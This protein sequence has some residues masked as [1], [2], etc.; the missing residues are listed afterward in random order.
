MNKIQAYKK[1]SS[2]SVKSDAIFFQRKSIK[3]IN[4]V[5]QKQTKKSQ[6]R[7]KQ[8]RTHN[9]SGLRENCYISIFDNIDKMEEL[10]GKH[11]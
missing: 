10:V 1:K 6:T 7:Q 3:Q 9:Y 4:A 5:N 8:K 2:A 11:N